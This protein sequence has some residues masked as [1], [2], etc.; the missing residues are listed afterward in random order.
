MQ[1]LD[2][3]YI[4]LVG[5]LVLRGFLK[6]FTGE[7]FSVVSITLGL[8]AAFLFFKNGAGFIRSRYMQTEIIPEII[9]FLI[10]FIAVFIAGKIVER[11]IKDI[12]I[13]L[14][15]GAVDKVLG[16]VFGLAESFALI[17]VSLFLLKIQPLFDHQPLVGGSFFAGFFLPLIEGFHV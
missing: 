2:I 12:I 3:A 7:L 10:I 9:A 1:T 4:I 13:R 17:V 16:I 15:L 6:G 8:I 5:L 14:N 11:I